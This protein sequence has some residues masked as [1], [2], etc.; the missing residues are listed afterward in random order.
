ELTTVSALS[1]L[2]ACSETYWR[3]AQASPGGRPG[4]FLLY[5]TNH[6][7]EPFTGR[8]YDML[9]TGAGAYG[10]HD[11]VFAQGHHNIERAQISNV[12]HLELDMPILYLWRGL[13]P[14]GG[15]P[16]RHRGGLSVGSVYKGMKNAPTVSGLGQR[17]DVPDSAGIFGGYPGAEKRATFIR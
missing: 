13:T 9:A 3:E 10:W 6:D 1:R 16:G 5:G 7:G 8:T 17:W 11:G 15:G 2:A 14:D 4:S 12:E